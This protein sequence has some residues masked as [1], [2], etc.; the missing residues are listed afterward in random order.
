MDQYCR[1]SNFVISN[2]KLFVHE[3]KTDTF[4]TNALPPDRLISGYA[5]WVCWQDSGMAGTRIMCLISTDM[6]YT[7]TYVEFDDNREYANLGMSPNTKEY[8]IYHTH[9]D[10]HGDKIEGTFSKTLNKSDVIDFDNCT[11]EMLFQY[12]TMY[13]EQ[14]MLYMWYLHQMQTRLDQRYF[15]AYSGNLDEVDE[16]FLKIAVGH[17]L[18]YE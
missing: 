8:T 2:Q 18:K 7:Q 16:L 12:S 14:E 17:G 3:F 13:S 1:I 4:H 9:R 11:E 5:D 6:N 10:E 15:Q